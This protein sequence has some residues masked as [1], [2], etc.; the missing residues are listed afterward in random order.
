MASFAALTGQQLPAGAAQDSQNTLDVWLGKS[1]QG[2][3]Y[4]LEESYTLAL[5]DKRWKYIALRRRPRL[6]G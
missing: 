1:K 4:L 3:K 6:T 5:R 2:R